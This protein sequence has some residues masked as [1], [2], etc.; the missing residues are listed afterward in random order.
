MRNRQLNAHLALLGLLVA[1]GLFLG[2]GNALGGAASSSSS[3]YAGFPLWKDV[4][5]GPFAVLDEGV[6]RNQ[7]RWGVYAS[8]VG[9]QRSGFKHPCISV[10]SITRSGVYGNANR[11]GSLAPSRSG[12]PPVYVAI[13]DS[14]QAKPGGA[15]AGESVTGLSFS[16][17]VRSATLTTADGEQITRR[18]KRLNRWQRHKTHLPRLRYLTLAVRRDICVTAVTGYDVDGESLFNL[19]TGEC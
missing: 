9:K 7:T 6:L 15:V 19:P 13:S 3:T 5:G 12:A 2:P 4:P 17:S 10:A 11:C 14:Y 16:D 8:R 1:A 18:T